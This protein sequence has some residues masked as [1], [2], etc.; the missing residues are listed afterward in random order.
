M[1]VNN[2]LIFHAVRLFGLQCVF[3]AIPGHTHLLL[4]SIPQYIIIR[5]HMWFDTSITYGSCIRTKYICVS[6]HIRTKCEICT[7]FMPSSN[8]LLTVPRRCFCGF[9]FIYIL[10]LPLSCCLVCS[11]H[12]SKAVVLF[13]F[14]F[15]VYCCSQ[16]LFGFCFCSLFCYSVL[17]SI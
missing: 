13:F 15:I 3:V 10:C 16:C 2:L 1:T 17:M 7:C 14:K 5:F 8:V 9:L 4:D 6:I 12:T 11:L